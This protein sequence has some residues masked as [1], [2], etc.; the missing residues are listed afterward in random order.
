MELNYTKQRL[1]DLFVGARD[2]VLKTIT[3]TQIMR[4]TSKKGNSIIPK[5]Q[6]LMLLKSNGEEYISNG[7][8]I[9]KRGVDKKIDAFLEKNYHMVS[10]QDFNM[11]T[12][13]NG[14]KEDYELITEVD[15]R[16]EKTL[17]KTDKTSQSEF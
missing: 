6:S 1:I 12:I 13:Y 17:L 10:E 9:I 3:A 5:T 15:E 14:N 2:L 8:I 11:K 7:Y 16:V 4:G